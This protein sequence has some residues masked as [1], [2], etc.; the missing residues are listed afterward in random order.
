MKNQNFLEKMFT[1]RWEFTRWQFF[2]YSLLSIPL[3]IF[4]SLLSSFLWIFAMSG[5]AD[6]M[7]SF[8]FQIIL[9]LLVIIYFNFIFSYKRYINLWRTITESIIM[10]IVYVLSSFI[11]IWLLFFIYLS[12]AKGKNTTKQN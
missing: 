8:Y 6:F 10:S 12:L 11:W 7:S 2:W 3:Y 5:S 4:I 1:T 9:T